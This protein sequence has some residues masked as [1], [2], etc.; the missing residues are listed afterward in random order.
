MMLQNI[1]SNKNILRWF[2]R[3]KTGVKGPKTIATLALML[4][5]SFLCLAQPAINRIEYY[6]DNDPGYGNGISIPFAGSGDISTSVTLNLIPLFEGVH[7]VGF[8][9]RDVNGVWSLDNKW[10]FVKPF[11]N[12]GAGAIPN[13]TRVE[14]YLDTDPGLGNG[15]PLSINPSQDIT[16]LSININL[17][18]LTEGVHILGMRS[19]D[20]NGAWSHDNKWIFLK[21]YITGGGGPVPNI[22]RVE[23][24][25][26]TDPGWGNGISIPITPGQDPGALSITI[27]MAPLYEG[28][29]II[30]MR[31]RDA[32]NAWSIDN[33]WLFVKPYNSQST[34]P[35][36]I[37]QVEYYIDTDPGYGKGVQLALT[38]L[39]NIPAKETFANISG[40]TAGKHYLYFRSKDT[41]QT[42]SFDYKDSFDIAAPV[43]TPQIVINSTAKTTM[44]VRDSFNVGYDVTGTYNAGNIFKVFLSNA[45]GDFGTETEVGNL[46][47]TKDGII[48]CNLPVSLPDGLGYKLRV[49]S[50]NPVL[51]G[52]ASGM[53]LTLYDR[54]FFGN[55]TT[56]FA[57]CGTDVFNLNA[58]YPNSGYKL[59]WNTAN[60]AAAD[61]GVYKLI[62]INANGCSDTIMVTI[63]QDVGTWTGVTN[64]SWHTAS[65]WSNNHVPTAISHVI[66]PQGTTNTCTISV[67]DAVAA[68]IHVKP[69]ATLNVTNS[70]KT[71]IAATCNALPN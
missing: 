31:S 32:N 54:P 16:G 59:N 68:S 55:D 48:K 45:A 24:Y 6:I 25:V 66:I 4:S 63:K 50:T 60:P 21:P 19:R 13:I 30:G 20:A 61:T 9:S 11:A 5:H 49:K 43:A 52:S 41:S 26:D 12:A 28:V 46:S 3:Q 33:R 53:T 38:P 36:T 69:G 70:R 18:P 47:S 7:I 23:Y 58:I 40:V 67:A 29:H 51:V 2:C 10:I 71:N 64:S 39:T 8:R 56:V 17:I 1:F 27:N 42:W 22:N 65:N 34:S 62:A 44:C 57:V 14:Y 35:R 37:T 15:T